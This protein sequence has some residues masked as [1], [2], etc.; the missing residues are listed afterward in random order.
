VNF[1]LL[2]AWIGYSIESFGLRKVASTGKEEEEEEEMINYLGRFSSKGYRIMASSPR[3]PDSPSSAAS[4][5]GVLLTR[6][7]SS[8]G[9]K[10]A[11]RMP[12]PSGM[13]TSWCSSR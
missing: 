7:D 11:T 3:P 9:D 13:P 4:Q 5:P 12:R 2:L 6:F 10:S 8:R 1:G